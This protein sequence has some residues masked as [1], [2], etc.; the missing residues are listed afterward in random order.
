MFAIVQQSCDG[1]E[2]KV[3]KNISKKA[4]FQILLLFTHIQHTD[5]YTY[6]VNYYLNYS[7][8]TT[9]NGLSTTNAIGDILNMVFNRC[10]QQS[11]TKAD[12]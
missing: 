4:A 9:Q 8:L 10:F 1:L 11:V 3:K 7:Y 6:E 12:V 2:K 5:I